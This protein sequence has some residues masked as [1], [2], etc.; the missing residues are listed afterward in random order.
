MA[1]S[2]Y[3]P[4]LS[5]LL[6]GGPGA[7]KSYLAC[8]SF[9]DYETGESIANGKLI[10]FGGEDNPALDL[11]EEHRVIGKNNTSLRLTSPLL[12]S[13]KFMETF[14]TVMRRLY[15]DAQNGEPLDVLVIDG[16][17][18]LDLMFENTSS[19]DGYDKWGELLDE[20]FA[21]VSISNHENL[22]CPVII[23]A[24]VSEKRDGKIGKK[25][26][27]SSTKGD[28]DYMNFNYYPS[29]RGQFRLHLP[30]YYSMVLYLDTEPRLVTEGPYAGKY[31]P[32]HTVN[33]TQSGKFYVKNQFEHKWLK[34]Q[35]PLRLTNITWPK[36]WGMLVSVNKPLSQIEPVTQDDA[37]TKKQEKGK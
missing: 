27:T 2:I 33:M 37:K 21:T 6:Y 9:F 10:T 19:Q 15:Q 8:S 14:R 24:R 4:P 12:D 5:A 3:T 31:L 35:L 11:P 23:T 30:H 36:L 22:L 1:S 17:S 20:M 13:R 7:G 18:E 26:G 29:L 28:P 16:L 25:D 32:Q 34:A